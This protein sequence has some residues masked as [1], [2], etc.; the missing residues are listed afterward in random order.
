LTP[1]ATGDDVVPVPP[2]VDEEPP[3]DRWCDL[4]LTGGVAS[5][6]VYPWAIVEIARAYRFRSIGGTSVGAMAAAL[7]AAAEY[8]R[9]SGFEAPFE[10]LRRLPAALG[11]GLPDGRTR[12]LSLFQTAD[13]GRRLIGLWARLFQGR[14]VEP[15]QA[16]ALGRC[17]DELEGEL[18]RRRELERLH[19]LER[20]GEASNGAPDPEREEIREREA[21]QQRAAVMQARQKVNEVESMIENAQSSRWYVALAETIRVYALAFVLSAALTALSAWVLNPP[22]TP[23]GVLL[24]VLA[25]LIG[26]FV[27]LAFAIAGDIG[28]NAI[29]NDLGLCKGGTVE[30]GAQEAD[31]PGM[32]EWLH[33]GIQRSA[34]LRTTDPPLTFRDLW[35]APLYP[36]ARPT[37]CGED[38]PPDQR[39]IDLQMITTNVTHSRPYRL[40]LR[41]ERARLFFL[42]ADLEGYFA[43]RVLDALERAARPYAPVSGSDPP[44]GETNRHFLE[45]PGA[46]LPIVV[47]ARLSLSFPLLFSAVPLYAIDYERR[48][49]LKK[50][51]RR[52]LFSDGGVCSN[53]PIHLFD[54]ALPRWPTFGL[55]LDS[56]GPYQREIGPDD[57]ENER[58]WLPDRHDQGQADNWERFDA[59]AEALRGEVEPETVFR[60][61]FNTPWSLLIGFLFG[62]LMSAKDWRDRSSFRLP[63]VRTRVIRLYLRKGEGGMHIGMPRAQILDMAHRY[64]TTV[65]RA[66]VERYCGDGRKEKPA[67]REQRWVRLQLLLSSVRERLNGFASCVAHASHC[68]PIRQAI[69]EACDTPPLR[70]A[71]PERTLSP[72]QAQSLHQLL[73]EFEKLESVLRAS[74]LQDYEPQPE[75]ELRLR[76]PL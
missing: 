73:S 2:P 8:G 72:Q 45:L 12:M 53:F 69:H 51:I 76:A 67:W 18:A 30:R 55:W 34:G 19:E 38:D 59:K 13:R 15:G 28:W 70:K 44:V 21:K 24:W 56:W 49:T 22:S 29:H 23:G 20:K 66:F 61:R 36:G 27:G 71:R 25:T 7:A 3:H 5:G 6:V 50:R 11:E 14:R 26:A 33:E 4:V 63:H 42:R 47:A 32:T 46:D 54:E 65:G 37:V 43:P 62:L 10:V 41:S 17:E 60:D 64:G 48:D 57:N 39:S 16:D 31:R 58:A 40:P 35:T 75:P 9:R 68:M 74:P 1:I 52:C